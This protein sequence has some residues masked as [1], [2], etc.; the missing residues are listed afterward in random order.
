MPNTTAMK[1]NNPRLTLLISNF[2]DTAILDEVEALAPLDVDVDVE[3]APPAL[4]GVVVVVVAA[5]LWIT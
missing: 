4:L 2:H 5:V 1:P 3:V